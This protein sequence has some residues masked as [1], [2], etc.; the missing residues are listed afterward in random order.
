MAESGHKELKAF[1]DDN[2][3]LK[4]FVGIHDT[5]LGP[6]A[7]GTRRFSFESEEEAIIDV[8][9]LSWAMT[10]KYAISGINMGGAKAVI[11]IDDNEHC[12]E[13]L[14]RS[15]GRIVDSFNGRFV[16]GGD[17]GTGDRELRWINM[18]TDYVIGL[19]EQ[20]DHPP[21]YHGGGLGVIRAMEA[22]CELVYGESDL[23]GVHVAIQ[24]I[25]EMGYSMLHYLNERKADVT[26]ADPNNEAVDRAEDEYGV[27]SVDPDRIFDVDCDVFAP[28]ALGFVINDDTIPRLNCDIVCGAANNQLDDE[29]KH[30]SMLHE[31]GILYAPDY[32]ANSGR[33]IDDTDLLRKGGYNFDRATAMIDGIYDRMLT[34]GKQS[35][36]KDRPTYE[37]ANEMA[38]HRIEAI[39]NMRDNVQTIRTPQW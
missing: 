2:T 9:R 4:G 32:L 29:E 39:G 31:A 1:R 36:Q 18:E 24:G 20:F 35:R 21:N 26:I 30:G 27:R 34:I 37:L 7:G 8:L 10:Y 5:T 38:E 19:P 6:A 17:I 33:T 25:G 23:S 3:G 12:S 13:E 14:Y 15:Y 22:C 28:S 16:T 11:W